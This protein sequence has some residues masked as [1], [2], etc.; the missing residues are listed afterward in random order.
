MDLL[1]HRYNSLF[2]Q[3]LIFKQERQL[4]ERASARL[5]I[6]EIDE[7]ELERNPPAVDGKVFP[8]NRFQRHGVYVV[9]EETADLAEDLLDSYAACAH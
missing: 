2:R 6:H 4:L 5:G 8:I 3:R 9:G 1:L 7:Q